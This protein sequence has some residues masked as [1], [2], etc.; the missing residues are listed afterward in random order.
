MMDVAGAARIPVT[1]L[2]GRSPAG[3]NSTGESDM[4]NY[5]DYIDGLRETMFR[6]VLEKLLPIMAVSCWGHVPDDL[7]IAFPPMRTPDA[8]EIAEI[9]AKNTSAI[10]AAYQNDLIDR[11]TAMQELQNLSDETGIFAKITDKDVE[12][13]KGIRYTDSKLMNDPLAGLM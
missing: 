9:T 10:I 6:P 11:A 12:A 5:Y 7:E 8:N 3:M 2:F 13:N 4:N 1:K